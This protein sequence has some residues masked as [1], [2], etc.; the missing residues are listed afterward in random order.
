ML[1]LWISYKNVTFNM[2]FYRFAQGMNTMANW[3]IYGVNTFFVLY[4]RLYAIL[5]KQTCEN[6]K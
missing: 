3:L 1:H 6:Y 5:G 4:T 2:M